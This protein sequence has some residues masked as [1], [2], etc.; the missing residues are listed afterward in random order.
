MNY[1]QLRGVRKEYH[2]NL[3]LAGI[4]LTVR[5]GEV[6]AVFGP[7]GAGKT[8]LM[9]TMAGITSPTEGKIV[10]F[11]DSSRDDVRKEIFFLGHKNS[12]YNGL[13]VLENISFFYR[14]FSGDRNGDALRRVMKEQGLWER[15]NDPVRELSQGTKRRLAITRGLLTDCKVYILDEPF[16]GLDV[17]WRGS[18]ISRIKGLKGDGKAVVI[19]THLV[20]EGFDLADVIAFLHRGRLLFVREKRETTVEEINRLFD[21]YGERVP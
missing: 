4:D 6:M 10:Y 20:E 19:A 15:R 14:L 9:K 3:A 11:G 1:I 17:K 12:L 16:T 13:T 21:M 5:A 2:G 8:T 18:M 7:N